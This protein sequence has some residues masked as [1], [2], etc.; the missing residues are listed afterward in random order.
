MVMRFDPYRDLDRLAQQL[1]GNL[2]EPSTTVPM[3][4]YRRGDQVFVHLDLPGVE[5]KAI[6]VTAEQNTLT[7][8]AERRWRAEEDDVLIARERPQGVFVR[9]LMLGAE[10]DTQE[11]EA[12]YEDGVLTLT[13]PVTAGATPRRIEVR[14]SAASGHAEAIDVEATNSS[15]DG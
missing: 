7:V 6:E 10:L 15:D 11:V 3:D 8:R 2:R 14:G 9:Q 12:A 4:A 5:P 1:A 13:L